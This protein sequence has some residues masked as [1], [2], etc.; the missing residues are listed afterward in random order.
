MAV[1][2]RVI[3]NYADLIRAFQTEAPVNV[4][5]LAKKMGLRVFSEDLGNNISGKLYRDKESQAEWSISVQSGEVQTRQRFTIAHE[6]GHFVLHKDLIGS[7]LEDDAFYRSGLAHWQETEAN[8]FA[9]D[10]LM[11]WEL[12]NKLTDAG[13]NTPEALATA[14]NV[15]QIAMNIRL[16]L[17][18]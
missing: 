9:A 13:V 7:S 15:S 17:P 2:E 5:G 1:L 11:P 4:V 3:N 12:I 16:G 14:F 18:T 6:L 8:N 10:I